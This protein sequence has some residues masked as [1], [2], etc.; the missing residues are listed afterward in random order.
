MSHRYASYGRESRGRESHERVF[1]GRVSYRGWSSL[2]RAPRGEKL[3]ER[4]FNRLGAARSQMLQA[5]AYLTRV[6]G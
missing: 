1:H 2:E 6:Y 4:L 5:W 3:P